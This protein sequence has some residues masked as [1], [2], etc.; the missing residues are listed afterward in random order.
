M[1]GEWPCD[2]RHKLLCHNT[3]VEFKSI[4]HVEVSYNFQAGKPAILKL[5]TRVVKQHQQNEK[6]REKES[7]DLYEYRENKIWIP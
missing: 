1:N 3:L 7:R 4:V 5:Y 2:V 6:S